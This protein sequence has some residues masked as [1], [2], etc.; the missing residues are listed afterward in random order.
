MWAKHHGLKI[1]ELWAKVTDQ[2]IQEFLA[3]ITGMDF[4]QLTHLTLKVIKTDGGEFNAQDLSAVY[5]ILDQPSLQELDIHDTSD[6]CFYEVLLDTQGLNKIKLS[7]SAM[8]ETIPSIESLPNLD[9]ALC[10]ISW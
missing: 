10:P 7:V 5:N 6:E 9:Y 4:T 3:C 2:S 1:G 8:D